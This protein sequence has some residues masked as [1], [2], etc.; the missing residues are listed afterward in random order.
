MS[1]TFAPPRMVCAILFGSKT[2]KQ[3]TRTD[4]CPH[5]HSRRVWEWELLPSLSCL[6][7]L[8]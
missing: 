2:R 5:S 7:F 4:A 8:I 1:N 6:C 3:N